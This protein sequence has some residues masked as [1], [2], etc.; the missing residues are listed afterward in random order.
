MSAQHPAGEKHA[1]APHAKTDLGAA[2]T[3]LIVG[4]VVIFALMFGI[5]KLTSASKA[6]H[7]AE[8]KAAPQH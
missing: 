1:A 8:V 6:S 5:V 7:S 4:A 2:L 3:G